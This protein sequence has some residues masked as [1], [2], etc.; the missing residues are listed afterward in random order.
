MIAKSDTHAHKY[1]KVELLRITRIDNDKYLGTAGDKSIL[2]RSCE[3]GEKLAFDY[4][5]HRK[6]KE[7]LDRVT[8]ANDRIV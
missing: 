7:R 3:C 8:I 6:M 5:A 2:L 4:G 1:E